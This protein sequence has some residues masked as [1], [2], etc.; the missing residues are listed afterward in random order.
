MLAINIH[1]DSRH[2]AKLDRS[3]LL[4]VKETLRGPHNPNPLKVLLF[5][6]LTGKDSHDWLIGGK[7]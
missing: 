6:S 4:W 2:C 5:R 1:P 7:V 3:T